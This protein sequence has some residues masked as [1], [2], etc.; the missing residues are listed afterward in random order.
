MILR[1][2][3]YFT[4]CRKRK[5]RVENYIKNKLHRKRQRAFFEGWRKVSH[6][7]FKE[8]MDIE[9]VQIKKNLEVKM[10]DKWSN[11]VNALKLYMIQLEDKIKM[12]QEAR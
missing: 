5:S 11:K 7:E 1:A 9:R 10:L 3:K 4:Q 12:E 2:W 8:R 6:D